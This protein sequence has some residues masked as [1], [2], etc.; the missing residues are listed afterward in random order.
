M[1]LRNRRDPRNAEAHDLLGEYEAETLLTSDQVRA[2][3]WTFLRRKAGHGAAVDFLDALEA[4]PRVRLVYV[5]EELEARSISWLRMRDE[6]EYS[7]VDAT[8][9]AVMRELKILDAMAFDGDFS[10]AG[11]REIRSSAGSD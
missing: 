8:S 3:T 5:G 11:F 9:F 2:E 6:R 4:S 7:F 1:A 10:A